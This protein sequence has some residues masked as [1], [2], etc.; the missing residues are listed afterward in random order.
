[1][2]DFF[3][4]ISPP[5][6]IDLMSEMISSVGFETVYTEDALGRTLAKRVV[7]EENSP[8]F[9]RSSMDGYSVRA[10]DTYGASDALPAYLEL[11]GEIPMGSE[12][13]LSLSPGETA[14]A[15][16]GGMLANNADA[17]VMVEHTKIT[18]TGLLEVYRPVASGENV[19]MAG[20]DFQIGEAILAVGKTIGHAEL[21]ALMSL[22]IT[23]IQAYRTPKVAVISSGDEL[24]PPKE[25]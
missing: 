1:M 5:D 19:I 4:V 13:F 3:N 9:N 2:A 18:P 6:A 24:V 22:G 11:V 14:T 17:V 7:S 16:T 21:G 25:K 10:S 23:S 20:E 8:S 15:Y 12:A